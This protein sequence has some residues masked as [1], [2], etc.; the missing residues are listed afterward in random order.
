MSAPARRGEMLLELHQR[1]AGTGRIAALVAPIDAR[2]HPRL[3]AAIAGEDAIAEGYGVLDGECVERRGGFAR[4][5][6]VMRRLAAN[7]AAERDA[8]AVPPRPADEAIG[9]RQRQGQ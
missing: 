7:D 6:V 8:S 5:N 4:H 2:P 9:K 3:L 1:E